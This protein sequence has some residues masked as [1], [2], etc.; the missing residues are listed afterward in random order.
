[1]SNRLRYNI[2]YDA[3]IQV[4]GGYAISYRV[5]FGCFIKLGQR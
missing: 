3:Y 1:M 4:T 5:A 2:I